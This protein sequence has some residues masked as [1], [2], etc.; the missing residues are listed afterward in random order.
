M[1]IALYT[2]Q[3]R[4]KPKS[5]DTVSIFYLFVTILCLI[6]CFY[7]KYIFSAIVYYEAGMRIEWSFIALNYFHSHLLCSQLW[8]R[9][10][11]IKLPCILRFTGLIGIGT[12]S[13]ISFKA[14]MS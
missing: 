6:L 2:I 13:V 9:V 10:S 1:L 11:L 3:T 4:K 7:I 8:Q 12:Q 5:Q 14:G